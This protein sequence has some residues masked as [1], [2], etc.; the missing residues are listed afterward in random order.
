MA[1][2][3]VAVPVAL[4]R[5]TAERS[6]WS[7]AL[8]RFRAH[9]PAVIGLVVLAVLSVLSL[10]APIVSPYDPDKTQLLALYEPPSLTHPFGTDDL[11]RDLAT[12]ILYGGRVS[13]SVGLL[14]VTVA[15]SIGTLVGVVAGYYG[16][17]IDSLLMRF[18]DMMYSFPRLFL[19]ILF[20]V[21]FKGMTVGV[22]VLVLGVLSWMTTSRLVRATFLSLKSRE[23]VEAARC[24]G[25]G[26]RRIIVRHILPNSLAP[27]IV[28][29]TL[30]VAAA[31]IAESTLSFLGL[32]IQPPTPSWG[33]MLNH[34]TTDMDKAPWIAFFPGFFI[35]LAV[36]SI[37]FIG[38][39]L[40]DALDPR[41]VIRG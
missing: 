7:M 38:D 22:I 20:G 17:W 3:S 41:H 12:R 39:G 11:G 33:N 40:R 28:A 16:G 10:L 31:I 6:Q 37:N 34:A 26:D 24:I 23:F 9:R 4:R 29:A 27:I 36:V 21:F 35:F 18:V 1:T 2:K 15:V 13:L 5:S 14:A 30:G 8:E 19:L 25:A 32:G